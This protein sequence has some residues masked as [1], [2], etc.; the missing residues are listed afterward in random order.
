MCPAELVEVLQI[1]DAQC[2]V[3]VAVAVERPN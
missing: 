3:T 2:T 1:D